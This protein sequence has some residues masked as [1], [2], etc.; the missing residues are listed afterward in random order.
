MAKAK[1]GP[2]PPV[3]LVRPSLE[4][5]SGLRFDG[6]PELGL[7][8]HALVPAGILLAE[9]SGDWTFLPSPQAPAPSAVPINPFTDHRPYL[10]LV[11]EKVFEAT[12]AAVK[13][14]AYQEVLVAQVLDLARK[15]LS[16]SDIRLPN[17]IWDGIR[18]ESLSLI[19]FDRFCCFS[20]EAS[21]CQPNHAAAL[22]LHQVALCVLRLAN[23]Q[24][25]DHVIVTSEV[26]DS[27]SPPM[28]DQVGP[29]LAA[30]TPEGYSE[31]EADVALACLK[32]ALRAAEEQ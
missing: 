21:S 2:L 12:P 26:A 18:P 3:D 22:T 32:N 25:P 20:D 15:N 16:H 29:I 27:L 28:K 14:T 23:Y 4:L 30:L 8:G 9:S 10:K 13:G 11:T 1:M 7:G 19:D 24:P 5:L 31:F 6:S 17:L